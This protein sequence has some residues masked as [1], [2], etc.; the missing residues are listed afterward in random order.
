MPGDWIT[1]TDCAQLGDRL[2]RAI[3]KLKTLRV[4]IPDSSRLARS[5]G[6]LRDLRGREEFQNDK[7][8]LLLLARAVIDARDLSQIA[9][10]LS[11]QASGIIISELNRLAKGTTQRSEG[12]NS[13]YQLQSQYVVGATLAY[14]GVQPLVPNPNEQARPD[15]LV[16]NGSSFVGVEVKR[17]T[18]SRSAPKLLRKARKQISHTKKTGCGVVLDLSDCLLEKGALFDTDDETESE[19]TTSVQGEFHA[20]TSLLERTVMEN[21]RFKE[22]FPSG[23]MFLCMTARYPRWKFSDLSGFR[24]MEQVK[25]VVFWTRPAGTLAH[26][27]SEWL[28][29][30]FLH[31]LTEAGFEVVESSFEPGQH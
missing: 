23:G 2:E 1:P 29:T 8:N 4:R 17:P 18:N 7:K 21:G 25:G 31:G 5:V 19:S 3:R 15:F 14:S 22:G 24:V 16:S 11:D 26:R 27:R 28:R 6:S 13:A 12:V 10:C 9:D 20:L 30:Q